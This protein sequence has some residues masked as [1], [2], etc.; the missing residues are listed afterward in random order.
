MWVLASFSSNK[1]QNK[2][3]LPQF[4]PGEVEAGYQEKNIYNDRV[5]KHGKRL[6][7]KVVE[8]PSLEVFKKK[9]QAWHFVVCFSGQDSFW[10]RIGFRDLGDLFQP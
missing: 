10:S 4:A 7:R 6:R 9:G 5:I 8:L 3:K 1:G 2:G